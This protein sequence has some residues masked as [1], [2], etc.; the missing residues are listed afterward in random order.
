MAVLIFGLRVNAIFK[1]LNVIRVRLHVMCSLTFFVIVLLISC[2]TNQETA[3][4]TIVWKDRKAVSVSIANNIGRSPENIFIR[5]QGTSGSDFPASILGEASIENNVI[6]FTPLIPFTRGMHYEIFSGKES[7]VTFTVPKPEASEA[8]KILAIYP[9][10]D[11][12]PENLLKIYLQ[13][14]QPMQEGKSAEYVVLLK[15]DADT[16]KG[17][18]LDLQPE[19]WNE[20][21]TQLTLWVDPGRIK[22]D[23]QP[24]K[25]LGAPMQ[26]SQ[27]Y[28][29][30]ISQKWKDGQ[31]ASLDQ[32]YSK[33]FITVGRDSLSPMP[34]SWKITVPKSLTPAALLVDFEEPLDH[35][36]LDEVLQVTNE[37]GKSTPGKWQFRNEEKTGLFVPTESW[38]SG[39]YDLIVDTRLEDLASNNVNRP[40]DRDITKSEKREK[41]QDF[42]KILFQIK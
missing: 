6:M 26:K 7:I 38:K 30:M 5:L 33:S 35:G 23:L 20:D 41:N 39:T 29:I 31:G 40:F 22:R 32:T 3:K 10:Q 36:L 2:S 4:A 25:R 24:N 15:I 11:T 12:L 19:L 1:K 14:S 13:F 9:T 28:R 8:P 27:G 42:V 21:R 37:K 18:F 16:V 17:A 34:K